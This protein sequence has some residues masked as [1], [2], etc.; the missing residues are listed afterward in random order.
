MRP[1]DQSLEVSERFLMPLGSSRLPAEQ[2][3][4]SVKGSTLQVPLKGR[5]SR[6]AQPAQ[7]T[8]QPNPP[9]RFYLLAWGPTATAT[10]GG[11]QTC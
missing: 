8:T 2:R 1:Q 10:P 11:S 4:F 6:T 3:V 7:F 5:G 9:T